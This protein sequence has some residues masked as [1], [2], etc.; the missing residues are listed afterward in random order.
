[1]ESPAKVKMQLDQAL[2]ALAEK[3]TYST[4][5]TKQKLNDQKEI[6]KLKAELQK[7]KAENKKAKAI[8]SRVNHLEALAK[9]L[10]ASNQSLAEQLKALQPQSLQLE[11]ELA[12]AKKA[13]AKATQEVRGAIDS[14]VASQQKLQAADGNTELRSL[15]VEVNDLGLSLQEAKGHIA[16]VEQRFAD[17]EGRASRFQN[18]SDALK[19][20]LAI[21]Q[22][23]E[24]VVPTC[25][26][27]FSSPL[28]FCHLLA[29]LTRCLDVCVRALLGAYLPTPGIQRPI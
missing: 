26:F 16:V 22:Q 11:K 29:L 5:L 15:D 27:S 25:V 19:Q 20:Q 4:T 8:A 17:S 7:L 21:F 28:L 2:Q 10:E 23:R 24:Q 18:E 3:E 13:V 1:M 14:S 6:Q 12:E 9:Q